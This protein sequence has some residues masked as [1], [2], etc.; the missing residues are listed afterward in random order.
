MFLVRLGR[1]DVPQR[2]AVLILPFYP[3][4]G[5]AAE[6]DAG[7]MARGGENGIPREKICVCAYSQESRLYQFVS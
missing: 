2:S 4:V 1:L 7:R 6:N 3:A 5:V